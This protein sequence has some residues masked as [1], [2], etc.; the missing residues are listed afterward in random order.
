MLE[1]DEAKLEAILHA[2]NTLL[3]WTTTIEGI[4]GGLRQHQSPTNLE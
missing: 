1:F 4:I 2:I 3:I